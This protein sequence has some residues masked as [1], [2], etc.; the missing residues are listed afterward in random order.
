VTSGF[1][2]FPPEPSDW[3]ASLRARMFEQRIVFL[4]GTLTDEVAGR[5]AMELMTLDATGDSVVQLHLECPDGELGAAMG[6]MDVIDTMGVN[7]TGVAMG[8]VGGPAVGVLA[9]C[10]HRVAMPHARFHLC[11]PD[12]SFTGDARTVERWLEHRRR[13]WAQYCERLGH[14]LAMPTEEVESVL[15]GGP[16]LGAEE[17][18]ALRLVHEVARAKGEITALRPGYRNGD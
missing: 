2:S 14:A 12:A 3:G 11:E 9:A 6:V 10:R 7:V 5:A 13:Q 8:L 1:V 4:T 15:A 16:Y 18:I 17:A